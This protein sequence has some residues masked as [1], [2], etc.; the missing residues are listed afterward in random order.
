MDI[1]IYLIKRCELRPSDER[2][3]RDELASYFERVRTRN[4]RWAAEY[5]VSVRLQRACP[6][7]VSPTD[8]MVYV[9]Q[10]SSDSV[11]ARLGVAAHS[12]GHG[13]LTALNIPGG[14]RAS[15]VYARSE[16]GSLLAKVAFHE[17]LH[18]KTGWSN[19]RLHGHH[20]G[21]VS[22]ASIRADSVMNDEDLD[23]MGT[24]LGAAHPQWTGGCS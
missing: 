13:G 6:P 22:A 20:H 2:S 16:F 8:V 12:S 17:V 10:T 11:F 9:V 19:S 23:L 15:E 3:M 7:M 21:G 14:L 5:A 1:N 18:N 4:P 24:H